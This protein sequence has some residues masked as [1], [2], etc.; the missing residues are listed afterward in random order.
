[1]D[2]RY[3]L[4]GVIPSEHEQGNPDLDPQNQRLGGTLPIYGTDNP[5]EATTIMQAGGFMRNTGGKEVWCAVQWAED[6]ETGKRI[7][8]VPK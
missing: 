1:M 3:V 7:G 6:T 8:N 4:Y 2:G 5:H